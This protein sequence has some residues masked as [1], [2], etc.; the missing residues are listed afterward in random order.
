MELDYIFHIYSNQYFPN[1]FY[2][3]YYFLLKKNFYKSNIHSNIS[4]VIRR[5]FM[6]SSKYIN[7]YKFLIKGNTLQFIINLIEG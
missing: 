7:L 1:M 2:A 3:N 5:F 6:V 4:N